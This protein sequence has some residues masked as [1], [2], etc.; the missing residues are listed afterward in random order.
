MDCED[1]SLGLLPVNALTRASYTGHVASHQAKQ[2]EE[3]QE[4]VADALRPP[5]QH[6]HGLEH[7]PDAT[8]LRSLGSASKRRRAART[9]LTDR[10]DPNRDDQSAR[11]I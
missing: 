5:R 8:S 4:A 11:G 9:H 1:N 10:A 7:H 6:R 3:M 2:S